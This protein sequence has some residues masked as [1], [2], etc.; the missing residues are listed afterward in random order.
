MN[1][2]SLYKLPWEKN[3]NPNWWIEPTTF[4]QL[5]CPWCYRELDLWKVK[6]K[7]IDLDE[8]KNQVDKFQNTRNVQTISIAWWEPLLYPDIVNLVSYI[9]SK[10]LYT[11]IFTN[12]LE[13]NEILLLKLKDAW[14]T[15]LVIH[16]DMFQNIP[17]YEWKNEIELIELRQKYVDLIRKVWWVNLWFIMPISDKNIIYIWELLE[18]YRKNIDTINLIVFSNFKDIS[19][20]DKES[21]T[22]DKLVDEISKYTLYKPSAFLSKVKD[23]NEIAWLFSMWFWN[24][25]KYF[26]DIDKSIYKSL[27]KN[28]YDKW[29][30]FFITR[31]RK[32]ISILSLLLMIFNKSWL[33]ILK[34]IFNSKNKDI[35]YQVILIINPPNKVWDWCDWCP[36]IMYLWDK[37]FPSCMINNFNEFKTRFYKDV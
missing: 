33:N 3:D 18:F 9:S 22:C 14:L 19:W 23:N 4:C 32:K 7:H 31:K 12:W 30:K 25:D 13:L 11:K 35:Y 2:N 1:I 6:S 27:V 34:N 37:M 8:M 16:V 17:W 5:K 15:E 36:D 24:K 29:K 10:N 20:D 26:W 28:Y 21:L